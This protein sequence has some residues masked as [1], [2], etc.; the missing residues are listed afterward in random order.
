[1]THA[2]ACPGEALIQIKRGRPARV[3][4]S[5]TQGRLTAY[6]SVSSVAGV[7]GPPWVA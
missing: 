1:M 7:G 2:G 4:W 5:G 6:S 3:L